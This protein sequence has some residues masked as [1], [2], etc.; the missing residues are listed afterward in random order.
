MGIIRYSK[1][2][3]K[4]DLLKDQKLIDAIGQQIMTWFE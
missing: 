1:S 3:W 4:M 2:G